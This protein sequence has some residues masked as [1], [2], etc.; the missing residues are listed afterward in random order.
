M[1]PPILITRPP[2]GDTQFARALR[3]RFGDGLRLVLSP[4]LRIEPMGAV[5]DL[6]GVACLL[7]TSQHGVTRFAELSARRDLPGYA[8]GEATAQ[9]ARAHGLQAVACD[10][11]AASMMARIRADG[12]R[13]PFLHL[14]GVHAASDLAAELRAIGLCATSAVLYGQ[15]AQPLSAEALALLDGAEPVVVPLFSPRSAEVLFEGCTPR[16]PVTVVAISQA[17]ANR[18]PAEHCGRTFVARRPDSAAMLDAMSL[19]LA[20]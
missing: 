8:V 17:V 5:P 3:Q 4:I 15:K 12:A 18:V 20:G 14:R 19:A 2:P 11:D 16:R 1:Q 13:G 9:V 7:F 6:T 10:G